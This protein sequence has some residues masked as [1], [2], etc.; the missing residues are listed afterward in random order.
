[1]IRSA[2]ENGALS[3]LLFNLL[4]LADVEL[5]AGRLSSA[6]ACYE[7][8]LEIASAIGMP[9]AYLSLMS[10][11][12]QAWAGNE[13]A[14]QESAAQLIALGPALGA[15]IGELSGYHALAISHLGAARYDKSLEA[16]NGILTQRT[17]GPAS[18]HVLPFAIEAAMRSGERNLAESLLRR[19]DHRATATGSS[20]ALGL[21]ARSRALVSQNDTA[22]ELFEEALTLLRRTRVARDVAHTQLLYG[23]W[24]RR[25]RRRVD[26]RQQLR[27]ARDFFVQ[28]GAKGFTVR[29]EAELRATGERVHAQTPAEGSDLTPQELR[30]ATLAAEHLTNAEIATQLF[31]SSATV[32]YHLRKVYRKLSIDS[33]RQL[34]SAMSR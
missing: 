25:Q 13:A 18:Q 1:M 6:N 5:H 14:T 22:A 16:A 29:A 10:V 7:E 27:A 26:A 24:L 30:V 32:D 28:M 21:T 17:I 4:G 3:E 33:R 31:L 34:V 8:A 9:T 2:R 11:E 23:E 15:G 12:A 19:L 20:W